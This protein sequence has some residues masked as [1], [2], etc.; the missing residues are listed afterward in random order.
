VTRLRLAPIAFLLLLAPAPG[1]DIRPAEPVRPPVAPAEP[2][3]EDPPLQPFE[4]EPAPRPTPRV[5]PAERPVV[6]PEPVIRPAVPAAPTPAP[7]PTPA[8]PPPPTS[9]ALAPAERVYPPAGAAAVSTASAQLDFANSLYARKIYDLA[10]PEYE[11]FLAVV[12]DPLERQAALFRYAECLRIL[13]RT[14]DARNQ[15]DALNSLFPSGEFA[16][17]SAYRLAEIYYKEKDYALALPL[18]RKATIRNKDPMVVLSARFYTARCLEALQ[19]NAEARAVYSDVLS[20]TDN[21]PFRDAARMALGRLYAAAKRPGDA[22]EQY[23]AL[24]KESAKPEVR[25]EA[26]VK[27]GLLKIELGKALPAGADF[28]AALALPEVGRWKEFAQLGLLHSRF[29]AGRYEDI[30]RDAGALADQVA[31]ERRPELLMLA[32][33]ARRQLGQHREAREL[34]DQLIAA[35]PDSP[36][37]GDARYQRL[38][39]LYNTNDPA[40]VEAAD[41]CLKRA[42]SGEERDR[43]LLLKAEA[44]YKMERYSEASAAYAAVSASTNLAPNLRSEALFRLGWC[45][46]KTGAPQIAADAFTKFLDEYPTA[47]QRPA[48]LA[49]RA[50]ARQQ[51][52]DY[53]KA[54]ADFQALL[55]QFPKAKER[56]LALQQRA[57]IHGQ[58]QENKAM[59]D[60]F[61]Q[62]L[63]EF[64]ASPAAPQAHYWIGWAAF[65]AKDYR[66]A[67]GPL[68][69][70]RDLDA[71]QFFEKATLRLMLSHYYLEQREPLAAEVERYT[72]GDGQGRVPAE[73][74]R[75]LGLSQFSANDA[76][77]AAKTLALLVARDGEA[78]P[79]DLIALAKAEAQVGR[80]ADAERHA[81]AY[82]ERATEPYPRA[83]G[84]LVLARARLASGNPEGARAA[85]DEACRLQPEGKLNA[86][87]RVLLGDVA[88]ARG[89][90]EEAAKIYRSVAVVFDDPAI[91]PV[92]LEK[93]CEA[94]RKAGK[95]EEADKVLNQLRSRYPEFRLTRVSAER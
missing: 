72:S 82:L 92:A 49:Q 19:L 18:Y 76:A 10:A 1:Q 93:A 91:T 43:I 40:V 13:G 94:Y 6:R 8:P 88:A 17:P 35:Y 31:A 25:A 39:S 11:K 66:A 5:V 16:G 24:A 62:L 69:K 32:A 86:E 70:S 77:G 52:K 56:E 55:K 2:V 81:N 53:P 12:S 23:A 84:L 7:T 33:N 28:E 9:P 68:E 44:L 47:P 89:Q 21:N 65:E 37:A 15:Y 30:V 67:I 3:T 50:L 36:H 48:A 83:S 4:F 26:L 14:S 74:L 58:L 20:V 22:V 78:Q 29:A 75:W 60:G 59:A 90:P 42:D 27:G 54:L 64:P 38:V 34:Y 57:L 45:S 79:D 61:R 63:A 80:S 41:D 85:A 51:L 87:G 73:V 46:L 95:A 71:A